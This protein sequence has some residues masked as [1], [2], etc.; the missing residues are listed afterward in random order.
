M[1]IVPALIFIISFLPALRGLL[2]N[3][4]PEIW[5]LIPATFLNCNY[6]EIANVCNFRIASTTHYFS[7]DLDNG[8]PYFLNLHLRDAGKYV[9]PCHGWCNAV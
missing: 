3:P 1:N 6:F 9:K 2:S 5:F 8:S 7:Q 4:I